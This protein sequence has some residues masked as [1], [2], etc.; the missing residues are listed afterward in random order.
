MFDAISSLVQQPWSLAPDT[1]LGATLLAFAAALVG[2]V[3][4]R[5]GRW[6]RMV[7]YALVGTF[8]ALTG[9]GFDGRN[10]MVRLAIDAALAV[11][12][13][14]AGARLNLRW[15]GHNP[16]LLV[17]SILEATLAAAA[18][19]FVAL[20]LGVSRDVAVPL[21]LILMT[22]APALVL[23]VVSEVNASGQVTERL[24]ALSALN[25]LYAVVA[26]QLMSAGLSLSQPETWSQALAPVVF[27]FLGSIALAA[28]VGEGIT[29][30]AR[31]LDLRHDNAV[32][33]MVGCV[34]LALT[35]AK[36]LHLST[37]LVPLLAGIWIRNR[38]ERPWVWRRH[39]GS[40]GAL[41]VLGLF[42][43]VNASWSLAG[44]LPLMGIAAAV[45]VARA[46]AKGLGVLLLARP[47][48]LSVRQA[49]CL[50]AAL[51]PVSATAW[52][53]G[54][55]LAAQHAASG[56]AVMPLLLAC[57]AL[58]ELASPLI[59]M[60]CLRKAGDLDQTPDNRRRQTDLQE[61]AAT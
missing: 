7:G 33:L 3:V 10:P 38:S 25:A 34:M 55:D 53:L 43:V 14:E 22:S 35:V 51:S 42:V 1:L 56:L 2:E 61:G 58:L 27:S 6:P 19:F 48:G 8:I 28:V 47:S 44:V 9:F 32:L 37:L 30:V 39:F 16:W 59:V 12:L 36:T 24:I 26:L 60:V 29:L 46:V 21:A 31:R 13:F 45:L 54:L 18:V 4:W 57:I 5:V 15:L 40:L 11:L 41:L 50:G 49:L 23:R 20:A 52:I 17:S